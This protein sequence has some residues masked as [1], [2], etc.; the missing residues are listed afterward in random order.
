MTKMGK[1]MIALALLMIFAWCIVGLYLGI[2]HP[3]YNSKMAELAEQGNLIEFWNTFSSWKGHTVPHAH[4]IGTSFVLILIALSM[5]YIEF[6]DKTKWIIGLLLIIGVGLFGVSD[7][8][9]W[10]P[11]I[12]IGGA[13]IVTMVL[14]SFIGALIGIK[15]I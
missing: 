5:P 4:G 12:K 6:S 8:F 2:G 14:V 15:K 13:L 9:K 3:A 10:I 11:L 1:V 7:W